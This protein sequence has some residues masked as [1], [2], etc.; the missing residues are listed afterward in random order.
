MSNM[1]DLHQM[2][3]ELE[4]IREQK[5]ALCGREKLLKTMLLAEMRA[6]GIKRITLGP[7]RMCVKL[8]LKLDI[9]TDKGEDEDGK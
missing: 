2:L 1:N 5:R 6:Q 4:E 7:E 8:Q 9:R 3:E